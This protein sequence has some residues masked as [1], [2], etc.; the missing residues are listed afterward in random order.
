MKTIFFTEGGKEIGL[1]HVSRCAALA[2]G[3][4]HKFHGAEIRFALRGD[5]IALEFLEM[6]GFPGEF[7]DWEKDLSRSGAL[8]SGAEVAVVDS[9]LAGEDFYH[10]VAERVEKF[11]VFDDFFR[12]PY[13]DKAF[14]LNPTAEPDGHPRHLFGL[15]YVV[16]RPPFREVPERK[17]INTSPQNLLVMMGG[18]DTANFLPSLLNF[19]EIHYPKI[20]KLVISGCHHQEK[21]FPPGCKV[22]SRVSAKKM[23]KLFY[24]CDLAISAGGQSL[25]ELIRVGLPTLA[26]ITAENQ[27][28]NVELLGSLNLLWTAGWFNA[29][30]IWE[31]IEQGI[32]CWFSEPIRK[33]VAL[34]GQKIIDGKGVFRVGEALWKV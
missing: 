31:R 23:L 8:L 20:K 7:F 33:E 24:E 11:L 21:D 6:H 12:L 17:S 27:V 14:V 9:Y 2:E 34:K 5:E 30:E 18:V 15:E 4:R 16:L 19:L 25:Y 28:R 26:V 29:P 1:G 22:L 10:F 13:P 3:L 32:E